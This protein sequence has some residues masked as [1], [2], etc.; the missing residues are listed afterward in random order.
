MAVFLKLARSDQCPEI[1]D[2]EDLIRAWGNE[3]YSAG[4]DY[5]SACVRHARECNGPILECG[6]GLSTILIGV[7]AQRRGIKHAALE[8]KKSWANRTRAVLDNY[9]L[10]HTTIFSGE[11]KNYGDFDWYDP[12]AEVL[13]HNFD[14]IICDG[15]PGG[16]KGGR[17]GLMPVMRSRFSGDATILLDD[18][19]REAEHA[20]AL[21]WSRTLG[22]SL[23]IVGA[24]KPF[25]I[26]QA[27]RR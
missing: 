13:P 17:F 24:S 12:P 26:I 10:K 22:F 9:G 11:L 3:R 23:D 27:P 19:M 14:L 7:I 15:P 18:A 5:L 8:H 16:T 20:L 4:P 21:D 1:P 2:Y 25:A 6:S